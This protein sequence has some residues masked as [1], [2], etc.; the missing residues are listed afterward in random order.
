MLFPRWRVDEHNL[1]ELLRAV[2]NLFYIREL[3]WE[4]S[5]L[6]NPAAAKAYVGLFLHR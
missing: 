2:K 4:P 1:A 3:P 6:L 5:T